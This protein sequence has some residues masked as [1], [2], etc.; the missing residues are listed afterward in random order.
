MNNLKFALIGFVA[1]TIIGV[2][3]HL[4]FPYRVHDSI[5]G[6]VVTEIVEIPQ[7]P[8]VKDDIVAKAKL[9][10]LEKK[11]QALLSQWPKSVDVAALQQEA[12]AYWQKY[13]L[14]HPE[15]LQGVYSAKTDSTFCN[16]DS[17]VVI[18][19]SYVSP[20]PLHPLGFFIMG[21]E[22]KPHPVKI[23]RETITVT[24]S[25]KWYNHFGLQIGMGTVY[26]QSSKQVSL[27]YYAGFGYSYNF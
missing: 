1:A 17:S 11:Y 14:L 6:K 25:I 4:S 8:I 7:A 24:E 9:T 20:I 12:S 19:A 21:C 10:S 13:Y 15:A 2:I 3:L 16:E 5:P 23:I 27:G 26:S 18:S 22:V